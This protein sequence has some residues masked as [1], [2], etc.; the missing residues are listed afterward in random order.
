MSAT[1]WIVETQLCRLRGTS[2]TFVGHAYCIFHSIT[3]GYILFFLSRSHTIF[4]TYIFPVGSTPY[5]KTHNTRWYVP[6]IFSLS[7]KTNIQGNLLWWYRI[8]N[9]TLPPTRETPQT[10]KMLQIQNKYMFEAN[11]NWST[12]QDFC[13]YEFDMASLV[14]FNPQSN[15]NIP[16]HNPTLRQNYIYKAKHEIRPSRWV[17][18]LW[19]RFFKQ[20]LRSYPGR[21]ILCF[22][23][24]FEFEKCMFF[25]EQKP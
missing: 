9:S 4:T 24:I 25:F 22:C 6:R 18:K 14:L 23:L 13:T 10:R 2:D 7:Q 17:S 19:N 15:P 20:L 12:L 16:T 8:F 3:N 21:F 1:D 5:R 11:T